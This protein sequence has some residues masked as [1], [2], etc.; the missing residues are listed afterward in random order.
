MFSGRH[1]I[2]KHNGKIFIDRQ[3]ESFINM[4]NYLR[5]GKFPIF[6]DKN[7]EINFLEELQFWQIP[8]N[9][10]SIHFVILDYNIK[11]VLHF[12]PDWCANTLECIEDNTTIKKHGIFN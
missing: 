2:Q 5:N 1:Q 9:E 3:G 10:Q 12:D 6:R 4:I 8:L 7:E 11:H